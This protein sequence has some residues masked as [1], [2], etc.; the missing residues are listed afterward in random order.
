MQ[1]TFMMIKPDGIQHKEAVLQRLKDEGLIIK[2]Y[3]EIKTDIHIMQTLLDHYHEVI[4]RMGKDFNYVGKLFNSFYFGDFSLI[5]LHVTYDGEED[6]IEKTRTLAGATNPQDA[7]EN[8]IRNLYSDDNYEK[9]DRD[10]RLVNNVIHA[11][12]SHESAQRELNIW[13]NYL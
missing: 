9:A 4:D 5:P 8:T 1:E 12:D 7:K 10:E 3:K 11:S 2:P 6:I 13:K